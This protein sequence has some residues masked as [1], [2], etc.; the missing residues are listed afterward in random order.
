MLK[1]L[2]RRMRA[3]HGGACAAKTTDISRRTY[4]NF[5]SIFYSLV[6]VIFHFLDASIESPIIMEVRTKHFPQN[7]LFCPFYNFFSGKIFGNV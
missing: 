1:S 7:S 6:V 4:L 5:Y 3:M 2:K